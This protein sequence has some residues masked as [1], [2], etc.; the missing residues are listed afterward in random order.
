MKKL[1]FVSFLCV[2]ALAAHLFAADGVDA[3]GNAN[4]GSTVKPATITAADIEQLRKRI[5]EQEE[6]IK[7]LQKAVAA[8][9]EL[10]DTTL[11]AVEA[12]T[13][14]TTPSGN[15]RLVNIGG[16]AVP[17]VAP[18]GGVAVPGVAPTARAAQPAMAAEP[19]P[20]QLKI[21]D[22]YLTPFGFMDLTYVGRTTNIGSGI[23]TN[24]NA[25]PYSNTAAGQLKDSY[26]AIQNSRI[27]AR[28]DSIFHDTKVLAYWESDFLG[29]QPTN[30]LV[31]SNS[32]TFRLRLLFADL[33]KGSWE[34]SAGQMWGLMTP[35]R[36]GVG[37]V[38]S[39]VFYTDTVDV[40]YHAGLVWDRVPGWRAIYHPTDTIAWAF[41]MENQQQY[42]GGSSGGGSIVLPSNLSSSVAGETNSG[43]TSFSAPGV[44]PDLLSKLAFDPTSAFHTELAGVWGVEKT[45]NP[46]TS[47]NYSRA[48]GGVSFNNNLTLWKGFRV[49]ENAT[50][51]Q[52]IG[53]Y[54]F[55]QGP[56]FVINSDASP[57]NIKAAATLDGIEYTIGKTVLYAYYGS[58]FF[59]RENV[60]DPT[61]KKFVGYGYTGSANSQARQIEEYT[62]GF[63]QTIWKDPRYGA[64]LFFGQYSYLRH[65]PWYITGSAPSSAVSN[66]F[67][68]NLRYQLP[69]SAPKLEV[70]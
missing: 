19:N 45:Y 14:A 65:A 11:R 17:G 12:S 24:F 28:F 57:T 7:Q 22:S 54:F 31:T 1:R 16:T 38:T 52:G 2:S 20:L 21:G 59:G 62:A 49:I 6:Q 69:G 41:G 53:R 55:G 47:N 58:W 67:F 3:P 70:K 32:Q 23:G 33:R 10:L 36:V 4:S 66:M 44:R 5:A 26:L 63:Q 25:A 51:G 13:T 64:L 42:V 43:A 40:N 8:Q 18:I 60:W 29:N 30:V 68:L 34:L 56:D 48:N 61:A 46:A 37:S 35:N 9:H 15:A 27:G 50:Y 39:D